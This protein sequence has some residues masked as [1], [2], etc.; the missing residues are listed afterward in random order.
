MQK[1]LYL[2]IIFAIYYYSID[3]LIMYLV[4]VEKYSEVHISIMVGNIIISFILTK[5][6]MKKIQ[7]YIYI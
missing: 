4:E 7:E 1:F 6:S 2:N 5:L 3:F